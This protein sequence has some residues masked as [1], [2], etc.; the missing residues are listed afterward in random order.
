MIKEQNGDGGYFKVRRAGSDNSLWMRIISFSN[1]RLMNN[2]HPTNNKIKG[3]YLFG[4]TVHR[5]R[6]KHLGP[7]KQN[8]RN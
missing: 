3:T 5:P 2:D 7:C 4:S 1:M 8:V 6:P